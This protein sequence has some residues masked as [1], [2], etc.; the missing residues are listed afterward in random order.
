LYNDINN[1]TDFTPIF[2]IVTNAT[3][4]T[5][6]VDSGGTVTYTPA[7]SLD[8]IDSF[9]YTATCGDYTSLPAVVTVYASDTVNALPVQV[10]ACRNTPV[11]VSMYGWDQCYESLTYSVLVNPAHGQVTGL[12]G[13]SCVYTSTG[14]N[15]TGTDSFMYMVTTPSGDWVTNVVTVTVGD[16]AITAYAQ[17]VLTGTNNSVA[18]TLNARS[19]DSC[20]ESNYWSNSVTSGPAHGTVAGSGLNVIYTPYS[21]FEGTDSFQYTMSDGVWTSSPAT[22]TIYMVGAPFL[23]SQGNFFDGSASLEWTED[24]YTTSL[25]NFGIIG[26]ATFV[27]GRSTNQTGPFSPILTNS[28]SLPGTY[29]DYSV[30]PGQTYYYVV[31]LDFTDNYYSESTYQSAFSN[32]NR[33]TIQ[34]IELV[35]P[36][37]PWYVTDW[38]EI[39][40]TNINI[41]APTLTIYTNQP[42]VVI[43]VFTNWVN[44][45]F[46]VPLNYSTQYGY[47]DQPA[48]PPAFV[49]S[50]WTWTNAHTIWAHTTLNLSGYTPQQLSNV[51]YSTAIDNGYL[52]Y[53]NHTNINTNPS[54]VY[55]NAAATWGAQNG[56]HTLFNPL[57]NI[58]AGTNTLDVV[59]WGDNNGNE[60]FSM[61]VTTNTSGW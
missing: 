52:L 57:P 61:V 26:S 15:F 3:H 43:P 28:D 27:L 39:S 13:S 14:T 21:N 49:N 44:G 48:L 30:S 58:V 12:S 10:Q 53:V 34:N 5:V 16:T 47:N 9:A 24:S 31:V 38:N 23:S 42:N 55:W 2:A 6:S 33:Q 59:F 20:V 41:I 35:A 45:P 32:T 19:S 36:T 22:V 11:T 54:E 7:T 29:W 56:G 46:S 37:S 4:G 8:E 25:L 51:V 50:A 40:P 60:Y 18:I 1:P 17:Y